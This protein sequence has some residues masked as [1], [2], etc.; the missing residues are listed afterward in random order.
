ML[1]PGAPKVGVD[2]GSS[3]AREDL[4]RALERPMIDGYAGADAPTKKGPYGL[5]SGSKIIAASDLHQLVLPSTQA[6]APSTQA[7]AC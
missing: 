6:E 3:A 2:K 5:A 4:G 1:T 7:E